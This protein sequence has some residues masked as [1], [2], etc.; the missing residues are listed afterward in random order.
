MISNNAKQE[1]DD[2]SITHIY[3]FSG[4]PVSKKGTSIEVPFQVLT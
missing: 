3:N 1:C 2:I 4:C